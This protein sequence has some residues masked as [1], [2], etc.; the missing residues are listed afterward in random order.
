M[1][2]LNCP[3]YQNYQLTLLIL[4]FPCSETNLTGQLVSNVLENKFS[5][6]ASNQGI[7]MSVYTIASKGS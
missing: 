1:V 2:V 5:M 4:N 6:S 7:E 3:L